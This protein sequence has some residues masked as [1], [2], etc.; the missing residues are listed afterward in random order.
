[1]PDIFTPEE[2]ARQAR[3]LD[4]DLPAEEANAGI[5]AE[6]GD[7]GVAG[8]INKRIGRTGASVEAEGSWMRRAGWS[9]SAWFRWKGSK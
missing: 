7:V 9:V 4:L 8:G 3:K 1:M 2:L 6:N 5:V